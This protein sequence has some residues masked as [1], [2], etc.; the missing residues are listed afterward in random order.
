M[1]F[2]FLIMFPYHR[3]ALANKGVD[4]STLPKEPIDKDRPISRPILLT[5]TSLDESA[6]PILPGAQGPAYVEPFDNTGYNYGT[7]PSRSTLN[8]NTT[9]DMKEVDMAS[10]PMQRMASRN[11]SQNHF[12]EPKPHSTINRQPSAMSTY[13]VASLTPGYL[14]P[15]PTQFPE[16]KP[17]TKYAPMR[18][19][20]TGV[21]SR[22]SEDSNANQPVGGRPSRH[23]RGA[24]LA[25]RGVSR[26]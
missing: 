23:G 9:P 11:G 25:D 24:S 6:D 12:P 14:D 26:I 2:L 17:A 7:G 18:R 19:Q 3:A 16:P 8:I 15:P 20:D 1:G 22:S 21:S 10:F 4:L 13:T 5:K